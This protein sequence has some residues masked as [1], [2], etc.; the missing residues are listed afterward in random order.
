MCQAMSRSAESC[1]FPLSSSF[2]IFIGLHSLDD[3]SII[4]VELLNRL[5]THLSHVS[6]VSHLHTLLLI[7]DYQWFTLS[8]P[9]SIGS[10][11]SPFSDAFSFHY[12]T[13][14]TNL[15]MVVIVIELC[16][17]Y[18]IHPIFI[19]YFLLIYVSPFLLINC[20][21]SSN[22]YSILSSRNALKN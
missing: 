21:P 7:Y 1:S 17:G 14:I 6:N 3:P 9:F 20:L 22:L 18:P 11:T 10:N 19:I 8:D 12:V 2:I 15:R 13:N 16:I 5:C 4:G